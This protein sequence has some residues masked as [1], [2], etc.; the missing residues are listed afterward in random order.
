MKINLLKLNPQTY[1]FIIAL[2]SILLFLNPCPLYEGQASGGGRGAQDAN[3]VAVTVSSAWSPPREGA[4]EKPIH[5]D[6][7]PQQPIQVDVRPKP[8]RSAAPLEI[9]RMIGAAGREAGAVRR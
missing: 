4:P 7:R 6:V 9:A 3:S 1:V 2:L 8:E 5:V